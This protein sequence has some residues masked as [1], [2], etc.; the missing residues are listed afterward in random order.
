MLNRIA[1]LAIAVSVLGTGLAPC[2]GWHSSA[3]ARRDC[4]A[5]GEC[6][7]EMSEA[8][9]AAHHASDTTQADADRCCASSE[10]QNQQRTSQSVAAV[11]VLLPASERVEFVPEYHRLPGWHFPDV[12]VVRTPPERLHLLFSVFLV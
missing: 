6:P 12:L 3:E 7:G 10:Q 1:A 11:F 2:A 4:C 9:A 5:N 8:N